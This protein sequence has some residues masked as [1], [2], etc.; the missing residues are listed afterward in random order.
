MK[1]KSSFSF[2]SVQKGTVAPSQLMSASPSAMSIKQMQARKFVLR[3]AQL[4]EAQLK[5]AQLKEAQK[6]QE[7]VQLPIALKQEPSIFTRS[8]PRPLIMIYKIL[9]P[10]T[11]IQLPLSD[12]EG[13]LKID[14]GDMSEDGTCNNNTNNNDKLIHTYSDVGYYT[15][16]VNAGEEDKDGAT[17]GRFGLDRPAK[18]I[19]CLIAVKS[20]GDFKFVSLKRAF[21]SAKNLIKVPSYLPCTVTTLA[22]M[23]YDTD[24]FNQDISQWDVSNVLDMSA[25]FYCARSFNQSLYTWNMANVTTIDG[26]F[27]GALMFDQDISHW[28]VKCCL[29]KN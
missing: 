4:R 1:N 18:G 14:W 17:I 24:S 23:F 2:I 5:E 8:W 3:E 21:A 11:K 15:V 29:S 28:H 13:E 27:I 26:M 12:I 22:G 7:A 20:W 6:Q 9:I 16:I 10:D 25:M 19:Q